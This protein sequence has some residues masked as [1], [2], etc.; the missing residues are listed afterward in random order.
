MKIEMVG[1]GSILHE[2][3]S[4]PVRLDEPAF[5]PEQLV[6][7]LLPISPFLQKANCMDNIL[8]HPD[9]SPIARLLDDH[10]RNQRMRAYHCTKQLCPGFFEQRGLRPLNLAQHINEFLVSVGPRL[11]AEVRGRF[12]SAY[13]QWVDHASIPDRENLLW[14][15]MSPYQVMKLGNARFF[16]YFGGEAL[17]WPFSHDDPCLDVLRNLGKPVVVEVAVPAGDF[18]TSPPYPFARDMISH[19]I[20]KR[21]NPK[22]QVASLQAYVTR[23]I[24]PHEIVKVHKKETFWKKK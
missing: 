6:E 12:E 3:D 13:M 14:F 11:Q 2:I 4:P 15:C 18:M 23:P 1:S 22:F 21:L 24:A 16:K 10:L 19:F 5:I 17:Y 8:C 7:L 20:R 9:F